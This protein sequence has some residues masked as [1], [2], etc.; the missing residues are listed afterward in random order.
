MAPPP[1]LHP[2][3]RMTSSLF[4]TTVVASFLVVALPHML[5]CPAPRR[6]FADDGAGAGEEAVPPS[7]RRPRRRDAH[8]PPLE[9][10]AGDNGS[11]NVNAGGMAVDGNSAGGRRMV[12]FRPGSEAS[13]GDGGGDGDGGER[14][15]WRKRRGPL[16]APSRRE[17]PVPKPTGVLGEWLGFHKGAGGSTTTAPRP[18][19]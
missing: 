6:V 11:G 5:P 4:A 17:C 2:R 3:S 19:R 1:H 10:E 8:A 7:R 12:E 15:G 9:C 14:E 16:G 13:D 18:D